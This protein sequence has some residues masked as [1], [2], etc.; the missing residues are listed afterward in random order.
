M[1]NDNKI[2]DDI[3]D[4]SSNNNAQPQ[5]KSN[6]VMP[7]EIT[8]M[9]NTS[10]EEI[11]ESNLPKPPANTAPQDILVDSKKVGEAT[12]ESLLNLQ[13]PLAPDKT[14]SVVP[15]PSVVQTP[16]TVP[17]TPTVAETID[18]SVTPNVVTE[19]ATAP[20]EV[21][22]PAEQKSVVEPQNGL[23]IV[24][25]S[26]VVETPKKKQGKLGKIVILAV[27]L[28]ISLSALGVYIIGVDTITNY[29]KK[30][31]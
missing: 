28:L 31:I 22:N 30:L 14:I 29:V 12:A 17:T 8:E 2:T 26:V 20:T 21:V 19:P 5:K 27:L 10:V 16:S 15:T 25:N 9:Y 23:P 13:N 18:A 7:N 3:L 1:N 11:A 4:D 24:E 6:F